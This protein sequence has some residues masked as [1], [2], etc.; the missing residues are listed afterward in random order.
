MPDFVALF[1][2]HVHGPVRSSFGTLAYRR[3]IVYAPMRQQPS[4]MM[5]T[6]LHT[7]TFLAEAN[8]MASVLPCL[9]SFDTKRR[10]GYVLALAGRYAR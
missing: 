8:S 10:P 7:R 5:L 4:K 6:N 2:R 9:Q 1:G 3:D